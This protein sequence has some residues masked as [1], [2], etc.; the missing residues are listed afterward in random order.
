MLGSVGL[1]DCSPEG[2]VADFL[3]QDSLPHE[4]F[5]F[6]PP[7]PRSRLPLLEPGGT[8][9]LGPRQPVPAG[10]L[11]TEDSESGLAA[12]AAQPFLFH[13]RRAKGRTALP[14]AVFAGRAGRLREATG[15]CASTQ[16]AERICPTPAGR[17][18][19]AEL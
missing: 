9:A 16:D 3:T 1:T 12:R 5:G 14:A 2:E 6:H 17:S 11:I 8:S 13:G 4:T 7:R 10:R 18:H 19:P 15:Q